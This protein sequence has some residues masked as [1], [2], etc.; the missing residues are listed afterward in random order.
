MVAGRLLQRSLPASASAVPTRNDSRNDPV[1]F[2]HGVSTHMNTDCAETWA[3]AISVLKLEGFS[4]P[5][6]TWGYKAC[7]TTIETEPPTITEI[8]SA[9]MPHRPRRTRE[10]QRMLAR[11]RR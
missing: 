3:N 8:E 11:V 5:F 6:V 7:L 9:P 1:V 2:V 10:V 4:G